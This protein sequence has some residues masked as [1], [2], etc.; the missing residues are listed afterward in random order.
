MLPKRTTNGPGCCCRCGAGARLCAV[1]RWMPCFKRVNV[2]RGTPYAG[3]ETTRCGAP[4]STSLAGARCRA[5]STPTP[6]ACKDLASSKPSLAT[7][8]V[9]SSLVLPQNVYAWHSLQPY[10]PTRTPPAALSCLHSCGQ[11]NRATVRRSTCL[12][13]RL[14]ACPT[15]VCPGRGPRRAVTRCIR[16][17]CL[18]L[19]ECCHLVFRIVSPDFVLEEPAARPGPGCSHCRPTCC[20]RPRASPLASI[21]PSRSSAGLLPQAPRQSLLSP[22]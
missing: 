1:F 21:H 22:T 16:V 9:G 8:E 14:A 15:C 6:A 12:L 20:P 10:S 3:T 18:E 13:C 7:G 17:W 5:R 11:G 2:P 19:I 4:F